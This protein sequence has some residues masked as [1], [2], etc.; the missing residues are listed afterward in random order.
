MKSRE[1]KERDLL[2]SQMGKLESP[3]LE[4]ELFVR[5]AEA[6]WEPHLV[7]LQ[8]E[9]PF[10]R[11]FEQGRTILIEPE[12]M[13]EEFVEEEES[14]KAD[15]FTVEEAEAYDEEA[16]ADLED[17]LK[18]IYYEDEAEYEEGEAS[19]EKPLARMKFEFQT[20]NRIWR[21]DNKTKPTL[22]PRKYGTYDFLVNS[23]NE[24]VRLESEMHGVLEF[25]T[26]WFRK[27]KNLK[28]AIEK[29]VEMTRK[30]DSAPDVEIMI[31]GK[32]KRLKKFPFDVRH[33]RTWRYI[34][35]R[36]GNPEQPLGKNEE[37]YV[38]IIDSTWNAGIQSSECFLLDYYESFLRQHEWPF[39]RDGAIKYAKAILDT[40]N[41]DAIPVTELVKLRSFLQ[42]IV[43]YIMR[44]QGGKVSEDA[45][46]YATVK[47]M[48][49]KQAFTLMSRTNFAS[50]HRKLLSDKE[51]KLFQKI[52]NT[53]G[54]FKVKEM[55]LSQQS[56]VFIEG[57]GTK[58]NELGPTVHEWLSGIPRGVDLLSVRQGKNLSAAMGRYDVEKDGKDRW[59]VKFEVRNTAFDP[60]N[61]KKGAW[62]E[63]KD[64]VHY[65]F[66]L[67]DMARNRERDALKLAYQHGITDE[68]KL[69]NFVFHARHPKLEYRRIRKDER[70]LA[71]KWLR[72]RDD[73]VRP[74][75]QGIQPELEE[76]EGEEE[77]YEQPHHVNSDMEE[78]EADNED[79]S[80]EQIAETEG[81]V[82]VGAEEAEGSIEYR[83][84][85]PVLLDIA[86]KTIAREVPFVE[87]E[88]PSRWTYCFSAEDIAKVQKAY[89]DNATAAS[90]NSVDRCS[91]IVMLNVALG[92]LLSLR[93]KQNR[94][95][96]TSERRVQM[97]DLTTETI[98]K[99]MQQLRRKGY[100]VAPTVMNFFDRRGR[101]AGTL[102][103]E[104][105]K[106]SVRDKVL[107]N[108]K[109]EGCWFAFGMSIM[110]GYHS[111]LLL[112]DNTAADAK[113]YWL[114]QYKSGLNDPNA[115]VTDSLDQRIT[116]KTQ[117]WWQKV[118]DEKRK[119]YNT[120]IRLWPL[121]KPKETS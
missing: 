49:S 42:I 6:E 109:T 8:S 29:A 44:G 16:P 17:S 36:E 115:D 7:A 39:Y 101:T 89:E 18:E 100:T 97:G 57:Y 64:W 27:W 60:R 77:H 43:N 117:Y 112:V 53:N 51:K 33:L 95:R 62:R 1:E 55:G 79:L 48:A 111:V 3:F 85:D 19:E 80:R 35:G 28:K 20:T 113:I 70:D 23:K 91:C 86:E 63:A 93:L 26:E 66:D 30:I 11:A 25:E 98:E 50:M 71:Q 107:A 65:A 58:K 94:A 104:R 78:Y 72:I 88:K 52:V 22:L 56:R 105:L 31:E 120:T 40:A 46:A 67:F 24:G 108:S 83:E 13:E 61:T 73:L 84:I 76:S 99:A 103:P 4:E 114:D 68:V 119:G 2:S 38:E 121:R 69:T 14:D 74:L 59:L 116:D 9:S 41:T 34:K 82:E 87:H 92:Q 15:G 110:D 75:V 106:T 81:E 32:L 10:Q 45:G 96:G 5:E 37:L 102:K 12:E 47:D 90:S 118:M 21:Y 54:I